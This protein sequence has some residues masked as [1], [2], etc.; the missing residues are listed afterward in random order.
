MPKSKRIWKPS[1]K[2]RLKG[3][4][5][6]MTQAGVE[7]DERKAELIRREVSHRTR[8]ETEASKEPDRGPQPGPLPATDWMPLPAVLG[9]LLVGGFGYFAG[10]A[11]LAP[12]PHPSHW[13]AAG[14]AGIF[15]YVG[16]VVWHQLRGY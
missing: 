15:G 9:A 1:S 14:L 7:W 16:G 12:Y 4:A 8:G 13:I 10:E 5:K 2:P 6:A 3:L 11:A